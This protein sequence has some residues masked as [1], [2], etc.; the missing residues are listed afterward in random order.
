MTAVPS[1]ALAPRFELRVSP[2]LVA[3]SEVLALPLAEL[4][5]LVAQELDANP[6][7]ERVEQPACGDCGL[8]LTGGGCVGCDGRL[9]RRRPRPADAESGDP[10]TPEPPHRPS[11]AE[12]FMAEVCGKPETVCATYSEVIEWMGLQDPAVLAGFRALPKAQVG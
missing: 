11:A 10:A 5:K 12:Q 8:P 1:L 9:D 3:F 6:A 4:E 2:A 7:L